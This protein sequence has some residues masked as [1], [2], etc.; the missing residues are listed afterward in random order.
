METLR[1]NPCLLKVVIIYLTRN[2]V[3]P[4]PPPQATGR[5]ALLIS[6]SKSGSLYLI[7]W[8]HFCPGFYYLYLN[9]WEKAP[10]DSLCPQLIPFRFLSK[11]S[12]ILLEPGSLK[13]PSRASMIWPLPTSWLS[14]LAM[15]LTTQPFSSTGDSLNGPCSPM[16][17][18][19][20]CLPRVE[21]HLNTPFL[22]Y[23]L[24]S[25]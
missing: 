5:H 21:H 3:S 24:H 10:N 1:G 13:W 19:A 18:C 9:N 14:S 15:C 23:L 17:A 6:F 2:V 16:P 12:C 25:L 22:S 8:H 7:P 20:N 4:S 11:Y